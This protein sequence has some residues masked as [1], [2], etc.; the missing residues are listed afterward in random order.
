MATYSTQWIYIGNFSPLDTNEGNYTN[1]HDNIPIGNYDNSVMSLETITVN[2]TNNDGVIRDDDYGYPAEPISYTLGGVTHNTTLDAE[3]TYNAVVTY[4]DG[5][6][7]NIIIELYQMQ[8]GATFL[9][10]DSIL[11]GAHIQNIQ[12]TSFNG[13]GYTG[14][15][16]LVDFGLN[17]TPTSTV[18]IVCFARGTL[19]D[20]PAGPVAIET[21]KAG[22]PVRT[23]D[24]GTQEIRWIGSTT[25]P[26]TGKLAPVV[27]TKGALGNSRELLVSPQHRMLVS[28]WKAE[29]LFGEP[30][31]LAAATHLV[32]GDTIYR[33]EGGEVEYFHMMFDTHEIVFAEGA[34]CES[35]HPGE[36][37]LNALN[38]ATREEIFTLFP[39]LR[40]NPASYG[41]TTRTALKGFEARVIGL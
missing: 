22:D 30:Q 5:T 3:A 41:P 26:A 19:I 34:P 2:D 16:H 31:V 38:T 35:F 13:D 11:D 17:D 7:S 25:V 24:H 18:L 15:G 33:R 4:G 32:N 29:L 1:E 23:L 39:E 8:D 36:M 40:T 37:G 10:R 9:S 20:T 12:I 6:T 27:I 14:I 28:G 21:L